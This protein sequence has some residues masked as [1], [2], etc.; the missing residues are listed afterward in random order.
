MPLEN[1]LASH[2][3]ISE[4]CPRYHKYVHRS[5]RA[6]SWRPCS[7]WNRTSRTSRAI[8]GA[9]A[10]ESVTCRALKFAPSPEN[11]QEPYLWRVVFAVSSRG[12]PVAPPCGYVRGRT[13][14]LRN[15]T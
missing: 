13:D 5:Y 8:C 3:E 14:F 11:G 10:A 9:C 6:A 7:L 15:A 1:E 4:A 12:S 2:A